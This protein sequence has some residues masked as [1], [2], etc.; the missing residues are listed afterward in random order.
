MTRR[1]E[2]ECAGNVRPDRDILGDI[3]GGVPAGIRELTGSSAR[4]RRSTS[5]T[6]RGSQIVL[7]PA[8][9]KPGDNTAAPI[10]SAA[11]TLPTMRPV[12]RAEVNQRHQRDRGNRH[13][14]LRE[15][16][17]TKGRARRKTGALD[18]PGMNRS[19]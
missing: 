9:R 8:D 3:A 14:R 4:T 17:G 15:S 2:R 19:R 6:G 16:S 5:R 12:P 13:H 10:P 18:T 7:E 11:R 1:A